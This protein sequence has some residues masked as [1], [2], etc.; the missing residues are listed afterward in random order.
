MSGWKML[1]RSRENPAVERWEA[2]TMKYLA[3]ASI[4]A[5]ALFS[6]LPIAGAALSDQMY[7]QSQEYDK[8]M[9][10]EEKDARASM[11]SH[12]VLNLFRELH[13]PRD[14]K[15][16]LEYLRSHDE[17]RKNLKASLSKEKADIARAKREKQAKVEQTRRAQHQRRAE[18]QRA[19]TQRLMLTLSVPALVILALTVIALV[20]W[21]FRTIS[22]LAALALSGAIAPGLPAYYFQIL[23]VLVFV[24]AGVIAIHAWDLGQKHWFFVMIVLALL[25]NFFYPINFQK[26]TWIAVDLMASAVFL[27]S[28]FSLM[29]PKRLVARADHGTKSLSIR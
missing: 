4:I 20:K 19:N 18:E 29:K 11:E 28:A 16:N 6:K 5:L 8:F 22:L 9:Q 3:I 25:F 7:E 10:R 1:R 13:K 21:P 17:E 26:Q 15:Y 23:R 27:G 24:A 14:P 2:E 12:D